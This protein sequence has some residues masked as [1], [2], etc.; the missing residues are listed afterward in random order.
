MGVLRLQSAVAPALDGR[1]S[2]TALAVA[3]GTR[4][5]LASHGFAS[6]PELT[7]A[8][9]RRADIMALGRDGTVWIVE[10]KSCVADFRADGKWPD[11]REFC[12]RFS[13][14]VPTDF[15]TEILPTE[16]GLI[17][18]DAFG[19]AMVREA[20]EH[21]LNAARRKAVMLRFGHAAAGRLHMLV[22]PQGAAGWVE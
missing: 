9:G 10:I 11:Y 6:V 7:L 3:V 5:L 21:R 22:D 12:D 16:A 14:A 13:F 19:A 4:R 20:P 17:L 2:P 1:Q 8:S 15:P 18:A